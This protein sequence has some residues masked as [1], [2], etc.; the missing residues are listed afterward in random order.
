SSYQGG[1]STLPHHS[2]KIQRS[3]AERADAVLPMLMAAGLLSG[4]V[5]GALLKTFRS[6]W[7]SRHVMYISFPGELFLRIM[8]GIS[9]PLTCSSVIAAVGGSSIRLVAKLG[10]RALLVALLSKVLAAATGVSVAYALSPGSGVKLAQSPPAISPP[11]KLTGLLFD[12]FLDGLRVGES[13]A[14][15]V[16][17]LEDAG[18]PESV[19][20]SAA[21]AIVKSIKEDDGFNRSEDCS[22]KEGQELLQVMT[23]FENPEVNATLAV[24]SPPVSSDDA[25]EQFGLT[26]VTATNYTGL[27]CFGVLVGLVLAGLR[28]HHNVVLNVFVSLSNALMTASYVVM[29]YS[30][31]GICS[32]TAGLIVASGNLEAIVGPLFAFVLAVAVALALHALATMPGL[33]LVF[34]RRPLVPFLYHVTFPLAVAFGTSSSAST[35]PATITALED[36]LGLDP[37]LVRLLAPVGVTFNM[38]GTII[39]MCVSLLFF[40]QKN[41]VTLETWEYAL[42]G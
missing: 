14:A 5:L 7:S 15:Q 17:R 35:L 38:D 10:F 21:E 31:V 39:Y 22:D 6:P 19:I 23:V 12:R 36:G 1:T 42:I 32:V 41:S 24:A 40:A 20:A 16:G 27:V 34:W 18:F 26:K 2:P 30:P 29:W 3:L 37:H 11:A 9:M 28:D 13:L 25:D 4:I 33:L 8:C